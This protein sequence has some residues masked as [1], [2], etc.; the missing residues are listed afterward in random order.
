MDKCLENYM[1]AVNITADC[2]KR[3]LLLH[4]IGPRS[5]DEFE[6]LPDKGQ[7]FAQAKQRLTEYFQPKVNV[8]FEIAQFRMMRQ[9]PGESTDTYHTRMRQAAELYMSTTSLSENRMLLSSE[10]L[11]PNLKQAQASQNNT[12]MVN[13]IKPR[14]NSKCY[15]CGESY[16]HRGGYRSC[17]AF[18][19]TCG[20]CQKK[21]H[22]ASVCKSSAQG[23]NSSAKKSSQPNKSKPH[24]HKSQRKRERF[25]KKSVNNVNNLDSDDDDTYDSDDNVQHVNQFLFNVHVSTQNVKG[26]NAQNVSDV[27]AQNVNAVNDQNVND[28]SVQNVNDVSV[29]NVNAVNAQNVNGVDAQ[30]V[31]GVNN[32]N[33]TYQNIVEYP[34]LYRVKINGVAL[35]AMADTGASCSVLDQSTYHKL[36]SHIP[37]HRAECKINPYGIDSL[38]PIG[39]FVASVCHN[40]YSVTDTFFVLPG[41]SGCLL[42][43]KTSQLLHMVQ[44]NKPHSVCTVSPDIVTNFPQ[45]TEGIG[46]VKDK[47]F[48]LHI[49]KSIPGVVQRCRRLPFHMRSMVEQELKRLLD[50]DIIEPASGPTSWASPI[51]VVPK[52]N[53]PGRVR[54]C[55]DMK[56]ANKAIIR[57]RHPMPTLDD[58][59]EHLT[60]CSVFSKIDLR[61]GYLQLELDSESRD[62]TTFVTHKGLFRSKRL[63]FGINSASEIFQKEIENS[64]K[65]V[66]QARNISDD[67]I[68]GAPTKDEHDV[69]LAQVL[70]S[71]ANKGFTINLPKCAFNQSTVKYY[72]MIFSAE[73]MKPDPVKVDGIAKLE[74]PSS[75][76][77]VQS[78]LGMTN[79]CARLI[80]NYSTLTAPLRKLLRKDAVF[81]WTDKQQ[82]AFET[83]VNWLKSEPVTSYFDTNLETQITVDASPVGL[84][85][86]LTQKT[87]EGQTKVISYASR[88]LTSVEQRYSQLER[89]A[90]GVVWSCERF[91]IY[92][93]GKPVT[94]Y[95]DHKPLLGIFAKPSSK[96]PT[97]LERWK[98]RLQPYMPD[99]RYRPGKDNPADY[100]SRHPDKL[101]TCDSNEDMLTEQYVN[102]I[103]GHAV[104]K[105]MTLEEIAIATKGDPTLD[106]VKD[107][108]RTGRWYSV[109]KM[110][111]NSQINLAALHSYYNVRD[112][113]GVTQDGVVLRGSRV[114]VPALLQRKVIDLA[115]IGHQGIVKTKSLLREKVWFPNV[116]GMVQ[117]KIS[118]CIACQSTH[119]SKPCEPSQPEK[120]WS[121]VCSDP[122]GHYLM[123][124]CDEFSRFPE[125]EILNS[126][127]AKSVVSRMDK[128]FAS[129][130]IPEVLKTDNGTPFQSAQFAE[131]K[132]ELG[133]KHKKITPYW[134]EANG[135]AESFMKCLGKIIKCSQTEGKDWKR[136]LFKFL[137]NYRAT[138]HS[139][140]GVAPATALNGY[141]LRTQLPEIGIV[142]EGRPNFE[143]KDERSKAKMKANAESRRNIRNSNLK[144]G[145]DVLMSEK[146]KSGK[147]I[148]KFQPQPFKVI[149]KKG[150]MVVAVRGSEV[151]ARNSSNFKRVDLSSEQIDLFEDL[152]SEPRNVDDV[153]L[154]ENQNVDTG[155]NEIRID[156][157]YDV[158]H[159]LSNDKP[160]TRPSRMTRK[161]AKFKD[162]QM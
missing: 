43:V 153:Y 75:V 113:L 31:N 99:I 156:A 34:P 50:N 155:Q 61:Q 137:R 101:Q 51:V 44:V 88:S 103:A 138:P 26:V 57:E 76:S 42:S 84:G 114:V 53:D 129:R 154:G 15:N 115:H 37:L 83:I 80:P 144:I 5:F 92:V 118:G 22:F 78:L 79:F 63:S 140:T 59:A 126:L 65:N 117:E 87:R 93:Y 135:Q 152:R 157:G 125:V 100:L 98:I 161:P 102:F 16:P 46:K 121:H 49:D 19:T 28:V 62:I 6:T 82:K 54:I 66:P 67:I 128:I 127:T 56:E 64:I 71:L 142:K 10:S 14:S 38:R 110:V 4:Q 74:T 104:P 149:D 2:R 81:K 90:L 27:N 95:T 108:I 160:R 3:A 143:K 69:A 111:W 133:F 32:Q 147:L 116:D 145:D 1:L 73:G 48:K 23:T 25:K 18:G 146:V 58:L 9:K 94:I 130:G 141:S 123:V 91:H 29:Q 55:V 47:Q 7:S 60:G 124:I 30:T 72:G 33:V 35:K 77:E 158:D 11:Y 13:T 40:D 122:S 52:P 97:R 162:Y 70:E 8:E 159:S 106:A 119:D 134:P 85:A 105:A 36:F 17:P 139:S 68:I 150:S 12:S 89:E 136:E 96:L 151:K 132:E 24:S 107:L 41:K 120:P 86:V 21:N 45:I 148:P 112:E 20:L 109:N 39:K 131:F